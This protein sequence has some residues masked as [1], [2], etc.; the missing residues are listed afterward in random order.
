MLCEPG[1]SFAPTTP[2]RLANANLD[3]IARFHVRQVL[4]VPLLGAEDQ[5]RG[6]FGVLDRLEGARI[7]PED[8]RR[9]RALAAQV[10]V[11]L[12]VARNLHQSQQHRRRAE[13]LMD[14]AREVDGVLHLPDFARKFVHR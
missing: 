2:V 8:V 9:A 10:A 12:E 1:K 13:A 4:I 7:L 11:V 5:I 14:L 6:A 3:L